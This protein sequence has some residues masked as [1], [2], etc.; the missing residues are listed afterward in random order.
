MIIA[1]C[2]LAVLAAVATA[3]VLIAP[4][5]GSG[6]NETAPPTPATTPSPSTPPPSPTAGTGPRDGQL[7]FTVTD[8][9][10]G[11]SSYG[12]I[13][14]G[15]D[16]DLCIVKV[17]ARNVG[18]SARFFINNEQFLIDGDGG[19]YQ[20]SQLDAGQLLWISPGDSTERTLVFKV[21]AGTEAD[22]LE[23]QDSDGDGGVTVPIRS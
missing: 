11:E 22:H 2:L 17:T 20:A 15:I 18:N 4:G 10:C 21:P 7:E 19:R 1:L 6:D 12:I 8:S 3:L 9:R 5:N 23:L 14:A 16:E 13:F